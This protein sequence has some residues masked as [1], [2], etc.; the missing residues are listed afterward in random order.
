MIGLEQKLHD[1]LLVHIPIN[2]SGP[3]WSDL[4][5]YTRAGSLLST[6]TDSFV[7]VLKTE[8][9]LRADADKKAEH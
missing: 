8:I 5:I 2:A 7:Q 6:T 3:L 4:G 9:G 1:G